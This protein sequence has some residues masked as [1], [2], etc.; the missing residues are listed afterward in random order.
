M[1]KRLSINTVIRLGSLEIIEVIYNTQ[2][3]I[4]F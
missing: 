4:F 2:D 1:G 3:I